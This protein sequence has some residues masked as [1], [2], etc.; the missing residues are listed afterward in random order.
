MAVRV[1]VVLLGRDVCLGADAA[2]GRE[3]DVLGVGVEGAA[4]VM[5]G[6]LAASRSEG[7]ASA[8]ELE[9]CLVV[10]SERTVGGGE[11]EDVRVRVG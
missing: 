2:A 11:G 6:Q 9:R 10:G 4:S 5:S 1:A 3:G 7:A 8:L